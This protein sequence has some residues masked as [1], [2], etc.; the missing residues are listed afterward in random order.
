MISNALREIIFSEDSLERIKTAAVGKKDVNT[1]FYGKKHTN[2]S[3]AKMASKMYI[4]IKITNI[5]TNET[6][7]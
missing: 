4:F 6:L 5:Q 1:S 2:E 3:K 7:G